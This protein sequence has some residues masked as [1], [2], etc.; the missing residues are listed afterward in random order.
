MPLPATFNTVTTSSYYTVPDNYYR[1][2]TSTFPQEVQ[3]EEDLWY[4]D[5]AIDPPLMYSGGDSVAMPQ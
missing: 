1:G 3:V 5:L 2:S 4:K